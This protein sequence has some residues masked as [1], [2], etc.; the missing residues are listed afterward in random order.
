MTDTTSISLDDAFALSVSVLVSNGYSADHANAIAKV[1]CAGQRDECHSHGL[2]RLLGC[3]RTIQMGKVDGTAVPEIIDHAAGIVRADARNGYSLLAF[4]AARGMLVDKARKSGIAA[5]A[6]NHCYHFSALWPEV[7]AL[8]EDGVVAIAMTPSHNWVA[9]FGGRKPV[10]GTNP[11]AFAWPRPEGH[12]Y[13]FDFAT[14]T[15]ARGEIELHRR[16]G[17]AIP[18][19]WAVDAD[20]APT[21]SAEAALA[22]AMTVFGGYK[23]SALSTMIELLAGPLIGDLSSMESNAHD[24]GAG[25]AP[26]HGEL[27]LAFDP[28]AFTGSSAA[29]HAQRAEVI[30]DAIV[31]QGARLPSQRRYAARARSLSRGM[32]DIPSALLAEIRALVKS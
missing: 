30:F 18:A 16:A 15:V 22:G 10:F 21:S 1:V 23:G 32:M 24:N 26:Y 8:A 19:D 27:L 20:G 2:Y 11:L 28:T 5:L 12:P 25:V 13:V 9:P 14:S 29:A 4:D 17:K 3:V 6:I 31:D 7:E